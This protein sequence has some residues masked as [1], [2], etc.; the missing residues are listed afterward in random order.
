MSSYI[1]ITLED[2]DP[3][4]GHLFTCK[5]K[6]NPNRPVNGHKPYCKQV[7]SK[8]INENC[9]GTLSRMY[10]LEMNDSGHLVGLCSGM[11]SHW[12]KFC[13]NHMP[14]KWNPNITSCANIKADLLKLNEEER[15][16]IVETNIKNVL[17]IPNGIEFNHLTDKLR[18]DEIEYDDINP[19]PEEPLEY[20]EGSENE[21][22]MKD[23]PEES[24]TDSLVEN[25]NE[26]INLNPKRESRSLIRSTPQ[27]GPNKKINKNKKQ[28]SVGKM[29]DKILNGKK[30]RT[31][32]SPFDPKKRTF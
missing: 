21:D 32:K 9:G 19:E 25:F 7:N 11:N 30:K 16:D 14:F 2:F 10:C 13:E 22:L 31:H 4:T 6:E 17:S 18:N 3:V 8:N 5:W 12:V 28:M 26:S 29:I 27:P 1:N 15:F 20:D 23:L 24:D